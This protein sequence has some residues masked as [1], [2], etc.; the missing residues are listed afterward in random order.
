VR[1][2]QFAGNTAFRSDVLET[3][4]GTN[5]GEADHQPVRRQH[6]RDLGAARRRRRSD[7]AVLSRR[8]LSRVRVAVEAATDSTALGDR[9]PASAAL[10]AALA[11]ADRGDGLYVRY[12]VDEGEPTLLTGVE[13][14][15]AGTDLTIHTPEQRRCARWRSPTLPSSMARASSRRRPTRRAARRPPP[16]SSSR[17]RRRRDPDQ[18]KGRLFSH[19]RPRAEVGY[20][21]AVTG[22][23]RVTARYALANLQTMQIG[24]V[25]I[26]GNF[27]T[28]DS[29]I[30]SELAM[31]RG[32]L[33]TQDV[34]ADGAR[35]LRNTRC[36]TRST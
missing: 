21:V 3:V 19:G 13:V 25:V 22:P 26:R 29:I 18:L 23:R 6:Q 1:S 16:T 4:I 15:L 27:K 33:L 31:R 36:S 14:A 34:L 35:R 7:L 12:V 8:R 17:G 20:E 10:T 9:P 11:A 30:L 24:Q 5:T 28:R 2:I 32:G